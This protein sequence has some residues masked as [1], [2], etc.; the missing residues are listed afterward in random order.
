MFLSDP[1]YALF[2]EGILG[3]S[4]NQGAKWDK[5]RIAAPKYVRFYMQIFRG[6]LTRL[7]AVPV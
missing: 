7:P 2:F 6:Q 3:W 5:R 4:R 1:F